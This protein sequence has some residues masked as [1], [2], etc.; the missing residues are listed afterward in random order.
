MRLVAATAVFIDPIQS[1]FGSGRDMNKANDVRAFMDALAD[2]AARCNC[3]VILIRHLRKEGKKDE[4]GDPLYRGLG[5][6]DWIGAARSVLQAT[7]MKT[8]EKVL[9]QVKCNIAKMG[10][11][12][13]FDLVDDGFIWTGVKTQEELEAPK[14][15]GSP[16]NDAIVEWITQYLDGRSVPSQ[17]AIRDGMRA[18][19]TQPTLVKI[20]AQVAKSVK[21]G[22]AWH[23]QLQ[24]SIQEALDA[25]R[26]S[27]GKTKYKPNGSLHP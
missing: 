8:D 14:A 2:M 13:G 7:R 22:E 15:K 11:S 4:G 19:F 3:A 1:Y 5:S 10:P 9:T 21:R 20:K 27:P 23:W 26:P 16:K 12:L 6:I 18:G 24:T 25:A 17:D